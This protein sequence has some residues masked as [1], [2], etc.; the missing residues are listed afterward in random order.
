[1]SVE[2]PGDHDSSEHLKEPLLDVGQGLLEKDTFTNELKS[3]YEDT[4]FSSDKND[5]RQPIVEQNK[6]VT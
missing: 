2:S 6:T 1:M 3:K 5:S 4:A